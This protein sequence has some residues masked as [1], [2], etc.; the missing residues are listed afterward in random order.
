MQGP[1]SVLTTRIPLLGNPERFRT[2]RTVKKQTAR[3]V[4]DERLPVQG[5]L[6]HS[7]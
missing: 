7:H 6:Q 3:L 1:Q 2:I 5:L 4:G